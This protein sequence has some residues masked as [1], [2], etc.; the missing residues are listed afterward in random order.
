MMF[1]QFKRT[2]SAALVVIM[3]AAGGASAADAPQTVRLYL[4][5]QGPR[6]R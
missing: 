3:V 2:M 4:S 6:A 1:K 5:G